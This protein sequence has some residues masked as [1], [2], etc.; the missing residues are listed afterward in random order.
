MKRILFL[1][2]AVTTMISLNGAPVSH[3]EA[4]KI[5]SNFMKA[6]MEE[7]ALPIETLV[8]VSLDRSSR[9]EHLYV[10]T[11][12]HS[13]VIMS[14]DDRAMPV[15]GYALDRPFDKENIPCNML[16]WLQGYE[17][18]M[19]Y[20]EE[21][22]I[23]AP[24]SV[25]EAWETL[26]QGSLWQP[27]NR[28]E[29]LPLIDSK[30]GQHAPFNY[31]CPGN[32]VTGCV[33]TAMSQ[34]MK[35]WEYP[36]KGTG[37]HSYYDYTYGTQ[38]ANFGNTTYDWDH[39]T[40]TPSA[41]CSL[42]EKQAIGTLVYQ[43]GVAVE[44]E[45]G[46]EVSSAASSD[47]PDAMIQYFGYNPGTVMDEKVY[48]TD[49]GWKTL[50]KDELN[51]SRP[52]YYSGNNATSDGGHAFICDGYDNRDYFHFNWGW[53]G[54][55]DAYFMIGS[56]NPDGSTDLNYINRIITGLYPASYA[57]Q[58][59]TNLRATV[60]GENVR[61]TW[62]ASSGASS[63]NVYRDGSLIASQVS[64]TS[65]VDPNLFYGNYVYYVKALK[66]NGDRSP[67]STSVEVQIEFT[68]AAPTAVSGQFNQNDASLMLTWDSPIP[69]SA[70]LEYG[71][72][73]AQGQ[74]GYEG[75][76]NYWAQRYPVADLVE[77]AGMSI[78]EVQVY[79]YE[80]GAYK[81]Y[82]YAGDPSN[83]ENLL[84]EQS[85]NCT[86][87][88]YNDVE[89]TT[90]V[91]L[92]YKND[93]WVVFYAPATVGYPAVYC[94]YSGPGVEDASYIGKSCS[95]WYS[96]A[97]Q[98][99]SWMFTV[100][101]EASG[102]T[103]K[104]TRNGTT[105]ADHITKTE[106]RD[107]HLVSGSLMYRVLASG[108]GGTSNPSDAY[109]ISLADIQVSVEN[110]VGGSVSGGGLY[111]VGDNVT[112]RANANTGYQF[113]GWKENDV[114]VSTNAV[115]TFAASANRN[116]KASFQK[117]NNSVGDLQE[118]FVLYPNPVKTQL[119]IE[120]SLVIRQL[121]VVTVDGV[122]VE[123]KK[124]DAAEVECS[125]AGYAKGVYFLRLVTD[126]G[127]VVKKVVLSE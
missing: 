30:W 88:G 52:V 74:V 86:Y 35:Y 103:Y 6:K 51:Q 85:Y 41:S 109:S 13:F 124:V 64:G 34:I 91:P 22:R 93:L 89:L 107:E 20:L 44:M 120:S 63:Y 11:G 56:L 2:M 87:L 127:V 47:V 49:A 58:A 99:R 112:V 55:H 48:Y 73:S 1:L 45:Y 16:S 84:Y 32:S 102:L 17:N 24:E 121:E 23:E 28:A 125:M 10:F 8:E 7:K 101:L 29:V 96:Y 36:N 78:T 61:L 95:A 110:A 38:S 83:S 116:L 122:L 33:A 65:Y 40:F 100:T 98:N 4:L 108:L 12:D 66:S 59:P 70:A 57:V 14:A 46:T 43:C 19:L 77:F 80:V 25:R 50:I 26:K 39:M 75:Y 90:S 54:T 67:R 31:Y 82:L 126:E 68:L 114:M 106:Y 118:S 113:K 18:E 62:N 15:L 60:D 76:A 9:L 111:K 115:Y 3:V 79:L 105:I 53:A 104:V 97:S 72:G 37:S 5:A 21:H 69:Q 123:T 71:T 27:V 42:A 81:L 117:N 119:H 92:D 94:S